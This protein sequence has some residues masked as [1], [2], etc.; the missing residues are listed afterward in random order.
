ME[1]IYRITS[2]NTVSRFPKVLE[3]IGEIFGKFYKLLKHISSR[4]FGQYFKIAPSTNA[5][6]NSGETLTLNIS[7]FDRVLS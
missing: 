2:T 5:P 3:I 7:S 6:G 4:L 1:F